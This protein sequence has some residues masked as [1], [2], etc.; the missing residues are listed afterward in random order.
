MTE[1]YHYDFIIR[2]TKGEIRKQPYLDQKDG[3]IL[4]H[5]KTKNRGDN[6]EKIRDE[7]AIL[8]FNLSKNLAKDLKKMGFLEKYIEF[9]EN[10]YKNTNGKLGLS[11]NNIERI[12]RLSENE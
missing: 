10:F 8:E 6:L 3:K 12:R 5:K 9:G 4:L 7:M 2:S 1:K 11:K